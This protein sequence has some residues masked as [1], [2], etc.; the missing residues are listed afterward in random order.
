MMYFSIVK[1]KSKFIA[2]A[3]EGEF[4]TNPV[5]PIKEPGKLW[6]EFG[7]T[8]AEAFHKLEL[9]LAMRRLN[10]FGKVRIPMKLMHKQKSGEIIP[11]WYGVAY[12]EYDSYHAVA[13]PI[14]INLIVRFF[15][16]LYHKLIEYRP[17]ELDKKLRKA[18]EDGHN[19]TVYDRYVNQ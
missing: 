7:E 16:N 11:F 6:F 13:Y 10:I 14:P 15:R 18:Y 19:D 17:T 8:K 1:G 4:V 2:C 5:D 12:W 3:K 9:S